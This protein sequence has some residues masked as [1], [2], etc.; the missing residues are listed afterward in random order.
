M[1]HQRRSIQVQS[2][3][4]RD[5]RQ[6]QVCRTEVTAWKVKS[7]LDEGEKLLLEHQKHILLVDISESGRF[8]LDEYKKHDLAKHSNDEKQIFSAQPCKVK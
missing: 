1:E 2:E 4:R 3:V 8:T 5:N 6:H 7:E